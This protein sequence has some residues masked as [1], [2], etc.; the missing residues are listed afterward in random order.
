M[1]VWGVIDDPMRLRG[2]IRLHS[3]RI[4]PA[5]QCG[6]LVMPGSKRSS[7]REYSARRFTGMEIPA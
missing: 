5:C 6:S 7:E 4:R 3:L 1:M 2:C